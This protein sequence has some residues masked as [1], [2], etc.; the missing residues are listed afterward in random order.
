MTCI[1]DDEAARS[2]VGMVCSHRRPICSP[3]APRFFGPICYIIQETT[4][5]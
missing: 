4:N 1:H 2:V 3:H 5:M